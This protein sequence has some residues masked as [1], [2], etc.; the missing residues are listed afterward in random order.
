MQVG[1]FLQLQR[2]LEGDREAHVAAQ[3]ED[4][5][6]VVPRFGQLGDLLFPVDDLLNLVR[7]VAQLGQDGFHLVGELV[8]SQL[9]QVQAQQVGRSDLGQ[10]GLGGGHGDLRAGVGV[11]LSLIHIS[12]PTRPY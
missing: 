9:G 4:R 7:H 3:E 11:E 2:A 8:A 10:K 6:G 12:E 5:L 1:D